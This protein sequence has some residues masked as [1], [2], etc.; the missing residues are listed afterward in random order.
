MPPVSQP[1][2]ATA[3]LD[4]PRL[5]ALIATWRGALVGLLQAW[6]CP[7]P[8]DVAQDVFAE[9]WLSRDRFRASWD[10]CDAVAPWLRGIAWNLAAADRRR[11]A[12]QPAPLEAA[13]EP[14]GRPDAGPDDRQQAIRDAVDR[15]PPDLRAAV[16]VHYLERTPVR[17]T[18][19][20]LGTSAKTI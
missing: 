16:L 10:D 11:R 17:E 3:A 13:P 15:L 19:A 12:R 2:E 14:A 5:T 6:G 1:P 20:L 9:A 8:V 7:A 18:A 4:E